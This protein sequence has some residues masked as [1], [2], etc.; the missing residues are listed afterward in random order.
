MLSLTLKVRKVIKRFR[1]CRLGVCMCKMA[2]LHMLVVR[3]TSKS[4]VYPNDRPAHAW[5]PQLSELIIPTTISAQ[6]RLRDKC[7][8]SNPRMEKNTSI[9][10][11]AYYFSARGQRGI[12]VISYWVSVKREAPLNMIP[13]LPYK[14][15]PTSKSPNY[16]STRSVVSAPTSVFLQR[17]QGTLWAVGSQCSIEVNWRGAPPHTHTTPHPSWRK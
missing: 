15:T 5:L 13:A 17:K 6:T 12:H 14:P 2:T 9:H 7:M 10:I 11:C 3:D 4:V 8:N 1:G 16:P